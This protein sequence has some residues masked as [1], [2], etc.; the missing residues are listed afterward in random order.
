M[1]K[2]T[3]CAAL[4]LFGCTAVPTCA[5]AQ[6][7][8]GCGTATISKADAN[9]VT[10]LSTQIACFTKAGAAAS[11]AV[12]DRQARV[13]AITA[14]LATALIPAPTLPPSAATPAP[15][16]AGPGFAIGINVSGSAYFGS[17]RIFAN[18]AQGA[19][20]WKDPSAGWGSTAAAKLGTNGFPIVDGQAF[21][22]VAPRQV[23][24]GQRATITCTW[25]GA[26][27][28]RVDGMTRAGLSA[29][30]QSFTVSGF[31]RSKGG[32]PSLLLYL[33]GLNAAKPFGAL[34]CREAGIQTVGQ[35]E[36]TYVDE[37]RP[38]TVLRYLDWSNVNGNPA[39]VT[40]ANRS[41]PTRGG[42]DGAGIETE[43]DLAN[44][45][46]TDAWFTIAWN[47]DEAYVRTM[48]ELVRDRLAKGHRAY[49]E[50]SN[51]VWNFSF[52]VATQALN[53]GLASVPPLSTDKYSNNPK[54]YAEKAIWFH[55][56]L[57]DVFKAEPSR[58]VRVVASQ[59]DN[60]WTAGQVLGF[61]DM[62]AWTDALAIAPYFG[63]G[64]FNAP[65]DKPTMADLDRLF[66]K[67]EAMRIASLAK[68]KENKAVAD[69]YGKRVI[70]YEGGQHII[71]KNPAVQN[72]VYTAMQRDPRMGLLYDRYFADWKAINPD[73]FTVYSATGSISQYGAWGIREYAGQPISETP[74]RKAVLDA[75]GGR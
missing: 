24:A 25:E 5:F 7:V 69:K 56:I 4:A 54:R 50:L 18:L 23:W 36:K 62:A 72:E 42:T 3:L 46:G 61:R 30:G 10:K 9:S 47:A 60:P 57:T 40:L 43:I 58:L 14:V 34:D 49:F 52:P 71:P 73:L 12:S 51:E 29:S 41:T 68:V 22:L 32:Y 8:S 6:S 70:A 64:I 63:N 20:V 35:F 16:T 38:F 2:T 53:E 44:A 27:T 1:N 65:D 33:S 11:K 75:I 48:G 19:G 66:A 15:I 21:A 59:S 26:G 55:K 13:K 17:E 37:M 39:S 74:K 28:L 45:A 67:L 31:D